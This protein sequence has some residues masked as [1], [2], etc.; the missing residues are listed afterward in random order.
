MSKN[1]NNMTTGSLMPKI[2][3]FAIP[4]A[5]TGLLQLIYNAADMMVVGRFAGSNSL[6]AVGATATLV[7]LTVN[8]FIGLATGS[9]VVVAKYIGAGDGK[10][11][12][13]SVHTTMLLSVVSGAIVMAVGMVFSPVFLRWMDTPE[14]IIAL[15]ILYLRIYFAGAPAN[16]I[17][18]Y[19]AAI[20]R[21]NGDS[22]RPFYF[23]T[24]SGL[25]N[26]GLNLLFVIKFNLDVAGVAYA[27]IISQY[28]SAICVVIALSG[29]S[30]IIRLSFGKLRFYKKELLEIIRIGLPAG[31]QGSLFSISN[32]LIQS[33]VNS[34]GS[35]AVAGNTAA[36]NIDGIIYVCCNAVSQSAMTFASQNY[37]AKKY[38]R[39]G[40][41]YADCMIAVTVLAAALCGG[42]YIFRVPL[43]GIF[44]T[45][46]KVV[47]AGCVRLT[48]MAATYWLDSF[49]DVTTG[50]LRGMGRSVS[51]MVVTIAGVCLFRIVYLATYFRAH[52][53]LETIYYSYPISWIITTTVLVICFIFAY[54]NILRKGKA[55]E[56][57][58]N[59]SLG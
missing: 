24:A 18:N 20:L 15:S 10:S 51:P 35:I 12:H 2:I 48:I 19:G 38:K 26:I 17:Y 58:E 8:L 54:R 57:N 40:Q 11:V 6:A 49:M 47:E 32:V 21:A 50:Q 30:D 33:S 37:G 45:D 28:I 27:T 59:I 16:M 52:R 3:K 23:L 39:I 36:A 46:S 9:G 56:E 44:T 42:F 53:S 5:L 41:A 43:L 13:R 29:S 25:I 34:F 55:E 31:I 22:K 4:L 1:S 14:D 7:N